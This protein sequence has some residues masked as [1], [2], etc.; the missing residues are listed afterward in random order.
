MTEKKEGKEINQELHFL[1]SRLA[2]NTYN[3]FYFP[4]AGDC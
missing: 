4:I 1:Y 3:N 2:I